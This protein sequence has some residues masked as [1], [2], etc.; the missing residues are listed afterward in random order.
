VAYGIAA[1]LVDTVGPFYYLPGPYHFDTP[2]SDHVETSYLV[3]LTNLVCVKGNNARSIKFEM[4][5]TTPAP[6]G[7]SLVLLG[8]LWNH[9]TLNSYY[10]YTYKLTSLFSPATGQQGGGSTRKAF[11][12]L[13]TTSRQ[14]YIQGWNADV[15][16]SLSK[17]VT[18]GEWHLVTV[19]YDGAGTL[20]LYVDD[21]PVQAATTFSNNQPIAL[22]TYGDND[23]LGGL[24]GFAGYFPYQ[25]DLRN[26]GFY[27]Y[28]LTAAE[29][30]FV[31]E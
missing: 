17:P 20:S 30:G 12:V 8:K 6:S 23:W 16:F 19:T 28:A 5:S 14:I 2:D 31:S 22:N 26:I 7:W 10:I 4:K 29:A 1:A 24:P 25:G 9:I 13:L 3:Q 18:D 15:E 27:N 21:A 11:N